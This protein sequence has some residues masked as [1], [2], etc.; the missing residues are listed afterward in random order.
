MTVAI[1]A[2]AGY[3]PDVFANYIAR[4]QNDSEGKW[5]ALLSRDERVV[6]IRGAIRQ[7]P[8]NDLLR[9]QNEL[10]KLLSVPK[11]R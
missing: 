8:Q 4:Q 9:V 5:S 1:M 10:H 6:K 2:G 3:E 11:V 7:L